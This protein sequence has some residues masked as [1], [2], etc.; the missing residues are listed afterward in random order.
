M[1]TPIGWRE[2]P[3]IFWS[4][5]LSRFTVSSL[6]RDYENCLFWCSKHFS[7]IMSY[8]VNFKEIVWV[9]RGWLRWSLYPFKN[10]FQNVLNESIYI[11]ISITSYGKD[12]AIKILL[13]NKFTLLHS[14]MPLRIMSSD[15][16]K[17]Y[18][19]NVSSFEV[20]SSIWMCQKYR[21]S[22]CSAKN[23]KWT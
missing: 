3:T 9:K 17:M 16:S 7:T 1:V 2:F 10:P 18:L 12:K 13:N 22:L 4:V 19:F 6:S 11:V 14:K 15:M 5:A 8:P 20:P 21:K 23:I